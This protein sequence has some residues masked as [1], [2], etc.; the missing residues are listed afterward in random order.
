MPTRR[1]IYDQIEICKRRALQYARKVGLIS[2]DNLVD[3]ACKVLP[4]VS[5]VHKP[6][7]D[8]SDIHIH[9]HELKVPILLKSGAYTNYTNKFRDVAVADTS[10]FVEIYVSKLNKNRRSIVKKTFLCW[11]LRTSNV[12]L[13]SDRLLRVKAKVKKQSTKSHCEYAR[14][15]KCGGKL[16]GKT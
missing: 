14:Q 9:L 8:Q 7:V 4:Y 10:P 3:I 6:S 16:Y 13:S 12:K 15:L 5:K 2:N 11:L 1:E